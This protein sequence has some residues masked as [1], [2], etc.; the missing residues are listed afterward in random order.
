[1]R[2]SVNMQDSVLISNNCAERDNRSSSNMNF[3]VVLLYQIYSILSHLFSLLS[4]PSV[5]SARSTSR[6]R[7]SSPLYSMSPGTLYSPLPPPFSRSSL[8]KD[9]EIVSASMDSV[10]KAS[11]AGGSLDE[12]EVA[13]F[14]AQAAGWWDVNGEFCLLHRMNPVRVLWIRQRV[15]EH[16]Q[17]AS[18][19]ASLTVK[20][21]TSLSFLDVGS[22]GGLLSESLAKLG[23]S[24]LGIDAALPNILVAQAHASQQAG[25]SNLSYRHCTAEQ[26]VTS[27]A[28]SLACFDV[29]CALEVV[30][31]VHGP[32]LFTSTLCQLVRP[33]GLLFMSTINRT[34]L[35]WLLTI[36]GAEYIMGWA[37]KGTHDWNKFVMVEELTAWVET[38][39]DRVGEKL[40][41]Q[42]VDVSG[43]LYDPVGKRWSTNRERTEVNYILCARRPL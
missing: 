27:S 43:L 11:A 32:H 21:F 26:L 25:L 15:L 10:E 7:G 42:V 14:G 9:A 22:G 12:V 6:T 23:G 37:S 3:L 34:Y 24:V 40:G 17:S 16:I 31:H 38:S 30:E 8:V 13:K 4:Y 29:V 5:R 1:M 20:P 28:H 2:L 19:S 35:A 39:Q 18:L 41:M 36:V 33:G